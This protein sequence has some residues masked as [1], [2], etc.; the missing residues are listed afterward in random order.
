MDGGSPCPHQLRLPW[1]PYNTDKALGDKGCLRMLDPILTSPTTQ[2]WHKDDS[3][4]P[5]T[6]R[7]PCPSYL[8]LDMMGPTGTVL[9]P[10]TSIDYIDQCQG[11]NA[12]SG[13]PLPELHFLTLS[14]SVPPFTDC[15][16]SFRLSRPECHP[17]SSLASLSTSTWHIPSLMQDL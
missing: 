12:T 17:P 10:V 7:D 16:G 14:P 2:P 3:P 5:D 15:A 13:L 11:I 9:V 1:G 8:L 6:P 4:T